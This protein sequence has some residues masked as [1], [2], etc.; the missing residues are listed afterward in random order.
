MNHPPAKPRH[1]FLLLAA[2][3]AADVAVFLLQKYAATDASAPDPSTPSVQAT[4]SFLRAVL[5]EPA[6]WGAILLAPVQLLL[7][8]RVLRGSDLGWAYAI[9]ALAYPLTM[10]AALLLFHERY[11]WHVW[12]GAA[13]IAAG[14]AVLG[15]SA[16]NPAPTAALSPA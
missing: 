6:L 12:L 8:T 11:D 4:P 13:L 16:P 5:S 15:P 1:T 3:L 14:A 9:T 2:L 10:L 7:W